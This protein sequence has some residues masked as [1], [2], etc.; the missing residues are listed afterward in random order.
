M[1][2]FAAAR[3]NI[4]SIPTRAPAQ[5]RVRHSVANTC[6]VPSESRDLY[7]ADCRTLAQLVSPSRDPIG[8]D[9]GNNLWRAY[10]AFQ[11]DSTDPL[12]LKSNVDCWVVTWSICQMKA[13]PP[14]VG[15]GCAGAFLACFALRPKN[16]PPSV[17]P[18]YYPTC[19]G[20]FCAA[21]VGASIAINAPFCDGITRK[22]CGRFRPW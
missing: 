6:S 3:K 8:F 5:R 1:V 22:A 14:I 16:L 12:G 10:F 19:V 4:P 11:M 21:S 18:Y 2:T 7:N 13:A 15:P 9:D 17:L 20:C